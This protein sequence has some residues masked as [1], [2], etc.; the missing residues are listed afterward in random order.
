[1][2][3]MDT[4]HLSN[5]TTDDVE[6]LSWDVPE[7]TRRWWQGWWHDEQKRSQLLFGLAI[8]GGCLVIAG[9]LSLAYFA[10]PE[11]RLAQASP[12]PVVSP[13]P[14]ANTSPA[15]VFTGEDPLA[16]A[17]VKPS[18]TAKASPSPRVSPS[19][20][21]SPVPT[22]A[23]K[24]NLFMAGANEANKWIIV[25]DNKKAAPTGQVTSANG[26][27]FYYRRQLISIWHQPVGINQGEH[28]TMP[29]GEALQLGFE[30]KN[31]GSVNS[32]STTVLVRVTKDAGRIEEQLLPIPQLAGGSTDRFSLAGLLPSDPGTY[33]VSLLLDPNSQIVETE[34]NDNL[35]GFSYRIDRDVRAPY[36][37]LYPEII[38]KSTTQENTVCFRQAALFTRDDLDALNP[39]GPSTNVELRFEQNNSGSWTGWISYQQVASSYLGQQCIAGTPGAQQTIKV[40]AR[41]KAGNTTELSKSITL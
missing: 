7:V 18:S 10:S 17:S 3:V 23:P 13:S 36:L 30:L 11:R 20:S 9:G 14:D 4:P 29:Q 33:Q 1:M 37:A 41:D 21:V 40:Q 34:E 31:T 5:P 2:A 32:P 35:F 24:P 39:D 16:T 38:E 26:Q 6:Q 8:L 27:E 22:V 15:P 19:P 28:F 12:T 25:E